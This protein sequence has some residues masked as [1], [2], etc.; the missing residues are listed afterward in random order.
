MDNKFIEKRELVS[1]LV[2]SCVVR[3]IIFWRNMKFKIYFKGKMVKE[4][5]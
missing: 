3:G 4:E 2:G 5:V 1:F